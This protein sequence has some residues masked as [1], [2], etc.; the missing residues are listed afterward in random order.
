MKKKILTIMVVAVLAVASLALVACGNDA[1]TDAN[2]EVKIVKSQID[3]LTEV[4]L[5]KPPP[6]YHH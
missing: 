3:A 6:S 2:M 1:K 4:N 5:G